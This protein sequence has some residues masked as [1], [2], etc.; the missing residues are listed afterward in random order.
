VAAGLIASTRFGLY[1]TL[2]LK[3]LRLSEQFLVTSR[4]F[5]QQLSCLIRKGYR[6]GTWLGIRCLT[7]EVTE[8]SEEQV[9]VLLNIFL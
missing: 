8:R 4:I 9:E 5:N 7:I 3:C 2:P 1:G 6:A